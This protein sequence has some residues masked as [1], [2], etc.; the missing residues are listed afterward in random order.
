MPVLF[1]MINESAM[2]GEATSRFAKSFLDSTLT[3]PAL[4]KSRFGVD[5]S[6][7]SASSSLGSKSSLD[8]LIMSL[9][10]NCLPFVTARYVFRKRSPSIHQVCAL[11]LQ[12]KSSL[13]ILVVPYGFLGL[14]T[15]APALNLKCLRH[16]GDMLFKWA[17][18]PA[19]TP[20]ES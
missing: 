12:K 1:A 10:A 20:I 4:S 14:T 17:P 7:T 3:L 18:V 16:G 11:R 9:A 13:L 6:S 5:S 19:P 2:F 15:L 8:K